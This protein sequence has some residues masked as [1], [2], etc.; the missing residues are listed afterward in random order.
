[1]VDQCRSIDVHEKMLQ[2]VPLVLDKELKN[3][4]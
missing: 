4:R 1:M 2:A 3:K